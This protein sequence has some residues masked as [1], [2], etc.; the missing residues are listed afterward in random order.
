VAMVE[1]RRANAELEALWTSVVFVQDL[2]LGS[3]SGSS[4]L[5][6]SLAMVV[7][8]VENRIDTTTANG[9]RWGT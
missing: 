9:V 8:E 2:V 3:T 4:S 5:V 1:Q 6:A 7:E